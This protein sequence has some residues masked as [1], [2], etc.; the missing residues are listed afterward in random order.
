MQLT[1]TFGSLLHPFRHV[2]TAPT[3]ATFLTLIM[4]PVMLLIIAKIKHRRAWKKS[5]RVQ[6]AGTVVVERPRNTLRPD[7]PGAAVV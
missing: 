4:V 2:F 6:G 7:P 3:F 1:P 5:L